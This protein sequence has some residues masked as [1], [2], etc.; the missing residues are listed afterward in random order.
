LNACIAG[1]KTI[2]DINPSW[3]RNLEGF[4]GI[5]G[6]YIKEHERELVLEE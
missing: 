3:E 5:E 6:V 1:T 4:S 2:N